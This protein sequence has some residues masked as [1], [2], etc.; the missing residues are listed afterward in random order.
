MGTKLYFHDF[1]GSPV[2]NLC[3]S[4]LVIP[5]V[6][7]FVAFIIKNINMIILFACSVGWHDSSPVEIKKKLRHKH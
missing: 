1:R 6:S 3:C 5:C 4:G 7:R 2:K